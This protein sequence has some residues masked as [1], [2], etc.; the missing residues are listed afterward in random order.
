[1]TKVFSLIDTYHLLAGE[2]NG[3]KYAGTPITQEILLQVAAANIHLFID[4]LCNLTAFEFIDWVKKSSNAL[5]NAGI[6]GTY[7]INDFV[8]LNG[9]EYYSSLRKDQIAVGL[10]ISAPTD[11]FPETFFHNNSGYK[12]DSNQD[13]P[14]QWIGKLREVYV[15]KLDL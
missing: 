2:F 6:I 1:M 15:Y 8:V 14:Y 7:D 13:I 5:N 3:V 11:K 4:K 10:R 12:M 9:A